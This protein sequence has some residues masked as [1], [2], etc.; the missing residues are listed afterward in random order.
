M[1]TPISYQ[2]KHMKLSILTAALQE[3]TPRDIRDADPDKA[4]E[5]WLAFAS[6]MACPNI[7][8]SAAIH[9]SLAD[10]PPEA[11]I[12]PVANT[13]DLRDAFNAERANRVLA[14]MRHTGVG[15]SDLAYFDNMLVHGNAE[16]KAKHEFMLKVF[17]AATLLGTDAVC[18]FV[19][20]NIQLSMDQNLIM[21]EEQFIPLLKEAKA[22]GLTYRVE[23]CPM[24]GWNPTDRWHNN[25]AYTPATWIALHRICEKHGVGDQFRI[26]YDPSHSV[27]MGQDTRSMFQYLKDEGYGFLIAGF[28]VKGQVIDAKGVSA[29][30]YGGQTMQRGDCVNGEPSDNPADLIHAWKKQT[31]LCEHELPG[32]A[33]H[34]PLAYLQNRSVDWL[35][36][37][38]AARELLDLDIANAY[39]VVEHE[40]PAARIQDRTKLAPLLKGSVD[41]CRAIDEAAAAMYSIQHEMLPGLNIPVQG[42]GREAYRS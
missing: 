13:L 4:I 16:R 17:D 34:D 30:G 2:P 39:L 7:Q 25:I 19:G 22:R 10:V 5:D 27:L 12:D 9:P 41:F 23:Q 18:G 26:H 21:F 3:L 1:T 11:L 24:P 36:H 33:R 6:E 20:R 8:L 14:A 35:D 31:V 37:Q 15:L 42:T 40:Y 38:L 32:T 29:W 28:H